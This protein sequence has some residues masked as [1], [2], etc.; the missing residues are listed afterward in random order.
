VKLKEFSSLSYRL[1][2][3]DLPNRLTLNSMTFEEYLITKKIDH[4]PFQ[5]A[6]PMLYE[7]WKAE[8]E[9]V[10]PNSFT[11]QKLYLINPLRRK[12]LLKQEEVKVEKTQSIA[13]QSQATVVPIEDKSTVA[14]TS[15]NNSIVEKTTPP[16]VKPAPQSTKPARPVFKPKPKIN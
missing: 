8:F 14:S 13:Q 3:Y 7:S 10:H 11:A 2:G 15:S 12:Y 5:Q 6:E 9:Q 1:L 4:M 16:E